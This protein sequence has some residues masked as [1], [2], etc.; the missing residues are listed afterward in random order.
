MLKRIIVNLVF[1]L[2]RMLQYSFEVAVT[3]FRKLKRAYICVFAI[4]CVGTRVHVH[5]CS[6]CLL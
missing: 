4:A 6:S 3:S 1:L 5:V 2:M